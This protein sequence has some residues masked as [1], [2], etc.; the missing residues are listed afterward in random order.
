MATWTTRPAVRGTD[1]NCWEPTPP[2]SSPLAPSCTPSTP[3]M[4]PHSPWD[5]LPP[6]QEVTDSDL[7]DMDDSGFYDWMESQMAATGEMSVVERLKYL[8]DTGQFADVNIR[9]G[10]GNNATVFKAHRL[11]LATAS[12]PLYRLVYQVC[13]SPGPNDVT[14]IR[15]TD[16]TPQDFEYILKY[17]YTDQIDCKNIS[18]A[19]ELLRA[20]RKWGLAGLGIK[21]LT[22]LEEFVDNFEPT[23]EEKKTN[24][25]DLLVL[26]EETLNEMSEKCWQILT[27]HAN[28][29]IPCE[30]FLNLNQPMVKKVICHKD[31]KFE[32]QLKLFEAIRDWGLRYIEKH[33]LKMMQLG[34]VV[35]ELIKVIDFERITDADFINTVLT[36]ECLGKAEV[37]AF[38]MTHGLEIPRNLDFNNN[39]QICSLTQNGSL[40]EFRK[41]CRFRKG[42]RCPQKEI[43]QEHEV[44]FRVDKNIRLLGVGFGFLF[45]CT[46]MGI[47]VHC[48]GPWETHQWSDITQ[49]YCRVSGEKQETADVR[50]MF[51]H[52]VRIIANQSYKVVVKTVRMSSGSSEVELWGG[53]GGLYCVETEDAEFHFIKAAVD[54]SK[55]V[56]ESDGD[57]APSVITELLY[58]MDTGEEDP[59]AAVSTTHRKPHVQEDQCE[60]TSQRRRRPQEQ[61]QET[62]PAV[63]TNPWRRRHRPEVSLKIRKRS[64]PADDQK[65]PEAPPPCRRRESNDFT[66]RRP[67]T[68]EYKPDSFSTNRWRTRS[69]DTTEPEYKK[70]P[71]EEYKPTSFSTNRW[72]TRP[73]ADKSESDG[74]SYKSQK[75]TEEYK[76]ES[77]ST[78]RWRTKSRDE[79]TAKKTVDSSPYS[80]RKTSTE[81]TQETNRWRTSSR[82][83]TKETPFGARRFSK[84]D[85]SAGSHP[86]MRRRESKDAASDVP[87]YLR[88]R[89]S[90][91]QETTTTTTSALGRSRWA[92]TTTIPAKEDKPAET[93]T[94]RSRFLKS[95]DGLGSS[96][97]R[98]SGSDSLSSRY[99]TT[100]D[101]SLAR[102][103]ETS[104][105]RYGGSARSSYL[106][107][108]YDPYTPAGG[109]ESSSSS[110]ISARYSSSSAP[111]GGFSSAG[112]GVSGRYGDS[113]A[114]RSGVSDSSSKYSSS[115]AITAGLGTGVG[116]SSSRHTSPAPARRPIRYG[117]SPTGSAGSLAALSRR[118]SVSSATGSGSTLSGTTASRFG[119]SGS[120]GSNP[121]S[122]SSGSRYGS[123]SS[124]SGSGVYGASTSTVGSGSTL[125]SRY[126]SSD[127]YGSPGPSS[128]SGKYGLADPAGSSTGSYSGRYG[129]SSSTG[130]SGNTLSSRYGTSASTG[131]YSSPTPSG[132]S[133]RTSTSGLG[134]SYSSRTSSGVGARYGSGSTLSGIS[135]R[136]LSSSTGT[137]DCDMCTAGQK[138]RYN[139]ARGT[140]P[141][142]TSASS[143]YSTSSTDNRR[144]SDGGV[145]KDT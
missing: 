80:S 143:R 75:K 37:I 100:R 70:S 8:L 76:P 6:S 42:Y 138:S 43:Y 141:S 55:S 88:P 53:T 111:P 27:K 68:E 84:S 106:S 73:K 4:S 18:V 128:G 21:S 123:L 134:T 25:F 101:S 62:Q 45:S 85:D 54:P 32:N 93:T 30:G 10:Q 74:S 140:S 129:S 1:A 86:F 59:S 117:S 26:S 121:T 136:Y 114:T 118:Y 92:A 139:T 103:R 48:Q 47:N 122:S 126:S 95:T 23:N 89:P 112:S 19:F 9:V 135:S 127:R 120:L 51:L 3:P 83:E 67:S 105:S 82:E 35:E 36:S 40:L 57:T 7:D 20:S 2:P 116:S 108:R 77:F 12:Q 102:T 110:S 56:E 69:R 38:F 49:S 91:S 125:S 33:N 14:T 79:D 115:S 13:P 119:T 60:E 131:R 109:S 28:T 50:L 39:K 29:I 5:D 61:D 31:I 94:I 137:G 71:V 133:S 46:D 17:I 104:L 15:V 11:L 24:L 145:G 98:S 78:N 113:S 64:P 72:L 81:S 87:F 144:T 130:D 16:M 34:T 97:V 52:P 124:T 41:V 107:S 65:T 142:T 22:Y 99:G 96:S 44:R 58:Q 63:Q 132:S 90:Q 66:S